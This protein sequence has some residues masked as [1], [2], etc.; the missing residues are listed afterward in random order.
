V[1]VE[2]DHLL[3]CDGR[4]LEEGALAC[5]GRCDVAPCGVDERVD[6]TP[7]V[8]H[9]RAGALELGNVE[10]VGLEGDR[11]VTEALRQL[12][13]RFAPPRTPDA[14]VTTATRPSRPNSSE[15]AVMS[16]SLPRPLRARACGHNPR[17]P[18]S[19]GVRHGAKIGAQAVIA[20]NLHHGATLGGRRNAKPVSRSLH[21]ERRDRHRIELG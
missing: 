13:E 9:L 10:Y 14:P 16:V 15:T 1:E 7:A 2:A 21:D 11:R 8:E 4:E 20:L 17:K 3:D 19:Y 5:R 6:T 18:G 12:V